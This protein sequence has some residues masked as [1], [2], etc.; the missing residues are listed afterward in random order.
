MQQR[1]NSALLRHL[2]A[3]FQAATPVALALRASCV[4]WPPS[5]INF[6]PQR[7]QESG[8]RR[9]R[10]W[11]RRQQQRQ[12]LIL[13]ADVFIVQQLLLFLLLLLLLLLLCEQLAVRLVVGTRHSSCR[14]ARVTL[15]HNLRIPAAS[16]SQK[17]KREKSEKPKP[18][19]GISI[20][21]F[22]EQLL[23]AKSRQ[24]PPDCGRL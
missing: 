9:R 20:E 12:C 4:N 14:A 24:I 16:I 8:S 21:F 2:A 5:S 17:K 10:R 22:A 3:S 6:Q 23:L 13:I 18:V 11:P 7:G 19:S 1:S 15:A